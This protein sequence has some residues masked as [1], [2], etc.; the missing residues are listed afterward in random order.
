MTQSRRAAGD[1]T[2]SNSYSFPSCVNGGVD[3]NGP[4]AYS[5]LTIDTHLKGHNQAKMQDTPATSMSPTENRHMSSSDKIAQ[6]RNLRDQ[7][8]A[9]D[10]SV[11]GMMSPVSPATFESF[12]RYMSQ[13]TKHS[14]GD[15]VESALPTRQRSI[16]DAHNT[17]DSLASIKDAL[18]QILVERQFERKS[19]IRLPANDAYIRRECQAKYTRG[20]DMAPI[21]TRLERGKTFTLGSSNSSTYPL[22]NSHTDMANGTPGLRTQKSQLGAG[23][24][25]T[26]G[27]ISRSN[28]NSANSMHSLDL[29]SAMAAAAALAAGHGVQSQPLS[30]PTSLNDNYSV[31]SPMMPE[32]LRRQKPDRYRSG[33]SN[34]SDANRHRRGQ[35]G[36]KNASQ[37]H[38]MSQMYNEQ[39]RP[40]MGSLFAQDTDANRMSTINTAYDSLSDN[41]G[42]ISNQYNT[43][44]ASLRKSY[45]ENNGSFT[46]PNKYCIDMHLQAFKCTCHIMNLPPP[47]APTVADVTPMASMNGF[48]ATFYLGTRIFNKKTWKSRYYILSGH[49]LYRF[50]NCELDSV[51]TDMMKLT[52]SSVFCIEISGAVSPVTLS[53]GLGIG[54]GTSV[55]G[56][57]SNA[58]GSNTAVGNYNASNSS[59]PTV[60]EAKRWCVQAANPTELSDWLAKLK[61]AVVRAKYATRALPNPP[62]SQPPHTIPN[63]VHILGT[64]AMNG[65]TSGRPNIISSV[66]QPLPVGHGNRPLADPTIPTTTTPLYSHN[67]SNSTSSS[68]SSGN[69]IRRASETAAMASSHSKIPNGTRSTKSKSMLAS[70]TALRIGIPP[71]PPPPP[72]SGAS[73]ATFVNTAALRRSAGFAPFEETPGEEQPPNSAPHRRANDGFFPDVGSP[74][75]MNFPFRRAHSDQSQVN[76]HPPAQPAYSNQRPSDPSD[77]RRGPAS[78]PGHTLTN[79]GSFTYGSSHHQHHPSNGSGISGNGGNGTNSVRNSNQSSASSSPKSSAVISPSSP[80]YNRRPSLAPVHEDSPSKSLS[81]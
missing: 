31:N 9:L 12:E 45:E 63:S 37:D 60:W 36:S 62:G 67:N 66:S 6:Q 14:S 26:N 53:G 30:S 22:Y 69:P 56:I 59:A 18:D 61:A 52:P 64:S 39:R 16:S 2:S 76:Y 8:R 50:K 19:S 34:D 71:P 33:Q 81:N 73:T 55:F 42:Y 72:P 4:A 46:S 38:I 57:N 10:D 35:P 11:V 23:L 15:R 54:A 74:T 13:M 21:T 1:P 29:D 20:G 70:M 51:V 49:V 77:T 25:N 5:P 58:N 7:P 47:M 40:S 41:D 43:I 3:N 79:S 27:N 75:S 68:I 32:E 48:L 80:I 44:D 24:A 78:A 28:R 65:M 17:A